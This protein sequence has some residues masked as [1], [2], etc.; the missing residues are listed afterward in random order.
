MYIYIYVSISIYTP[1]YMHTHSMY[2]KR[3]QFNLFSKAWSFEGTSQN[4]K[5]CSSFRRPLQGRSGFPSQVDADSP[6]ESRAGCPDL[7]QRLQ[8]SSFLAMTYYVPK[9]YN[10]LPKK[11]L[12]VSPWVRIKNDPQKSLWSI[13]CTEIV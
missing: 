5:A 12:P 11:E 13:Y 7:T 1:S 3:F 9:G 10:I 8:C 4:M 2:I 6:E